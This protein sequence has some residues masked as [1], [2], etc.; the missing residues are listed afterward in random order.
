MKRALALIL[1]VGMI[2]CFSGCNEPIS[3]TELG[4][5]IVPADVVG[6]PQD[7]D[8]TEA[9]MSFA[10]ELFKKSVM[11]SEDNSILI[12]PLSVQLALAMT[13]NGANG[14]TKAQME[15]ALGGISVEAL[16]EYLYT[17]INSLPNGENYRLHTANSVWYREG[18][19]QVDEQF[20]T[21]G[22]AYYD[23]QLFS[24]PF[25][26]STVKDINKWV[27]NNTDGM[28]D[29]IVDSIDI[30]TVMYLINALA[31]DGKWNSVYQK[32]DVYDGTFTNVNGEERTVSMM[33][34]TEGQYLSMDGAVGF[35]KNYKECKYSFAAL[36][37]NE[38]T[39]IY[40]FIDGLDSTELK[41]ALDGF[42]S[43]SVN[44]SIPKFS[45][46][47]ELSMND[48][49]KEMGMTSAFSETADFSKMGFCSMGPLRIDEVLHKTF[50]SVDELGTKAG[51]VTKVE[52][53]AESAEVTSYTVRLDRP[54]VYFIIENTTGL[55]VFMGC[56]T[57]IN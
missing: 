53:K 45:Y 48:L 46:E 15:E 18:V 40:S 1:T 39:D 14:E 11:K 38:G 34:G 52:L 12:S 19:M 57:D 29:K 27:H 56:V 5:S 32:E 25:D 6:K 28:I 24:A 37:P 47:Y 30:D 41:S 50:I 42:E 35:I 55:P 26:N 31:F 3:A 43:A 20:I 9:S 4:K 22:R 13:A 16:N 54:F 23:A 10:L 44:A 2:I 49:L 36:L 33:N 7:T 8:F 17:Y 21:T 51:A